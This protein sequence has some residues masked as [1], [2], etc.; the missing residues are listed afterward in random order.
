MNV[1]HATISS[2]CASTI[3]LDVVLVASN[4]RYSVDTEEYGH[5]AVGKVGA[6]ERDGAAPVSTEHP[7]QLDVGAASWHSELPL[8]GWC[9]LL[10]RSV[11]LSYHHK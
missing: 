7:N 4:A 2:N 9:L 3:A 10:E 1:Y 8:V 5:H 11:A 6:V